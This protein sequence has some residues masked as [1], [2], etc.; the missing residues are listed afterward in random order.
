MRSQLEKE[1]EREKDENYTPMEPLMRFPT[2][3]LY[4]QYIHFCRLSVRDF[5]FSSISFFLSFNRCP[6]QTSYNGI[7]CN[8]FAHTF[9]ANI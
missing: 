9:Y 3:V 4:S 8:V 2:L 5:L 1:R 7:E 6:R